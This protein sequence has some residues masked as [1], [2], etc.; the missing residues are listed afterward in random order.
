[1]GSQAVSL[2]DNDTRY[3]RN[4]RKDFCS[5]A[6]E[7]RYEWAI[8]RFDL[9]GK[10]VLDFGC[11][12]GYGTAVLASRASSTVGVDRSD[13]SVEFATKTYGDPGLSY[14]S[15]DACAPDVP[16]RL[17]LFDFIFSFDV[18][19]HLERYPLYVENAKKM[20]APQ[21]QLVIGCP[22]RLQTL[23]WNRL[24]NQ[25][26]FQEF[27]PWQMRWILSHYF[28]SVV[29]IAQDFADSK[30]RESAR[31]QNYGPDP[32][33]AAMRRSIKPLVPSALLQKRR[34]RAIRNGFETSDIS[35]LEEPVE[36]T[37]DQA[38]GIIAI[39]A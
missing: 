20:L 5:I 29:M 2:A 32:L 12:S 37:L 9:T 18:I 21:G 25:Y 28:S 4:G 1:M 23:H 38:F 34:N 35:F 13:V 36:T 10:R 17:G 30:Q 33:R 7:S 16:T 8:R 6:H 3:V 19:E 27:S 22:N 14:L 39:C 31:L 26:H 11:G 24:W 15:L